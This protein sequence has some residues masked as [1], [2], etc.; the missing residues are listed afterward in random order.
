MVTSSPPAMGLGLEPAHPKVMKRPSRKGKFGIFT[1][2]VIVDIFFYGIL[3][4]T[5]CLAGF[6]IS[7]YVIGDGNL[8]IN[9]NSSGVNSIN[10]TT[11]YRSRTVSFISMS[12]LLLIHGWNCKDSQKSLFTM[13]LWENKFLFFSVII[14]LCLTF[15]TPYIPGI[16]DSVFKQGPIDVE[17][18]V[19][20][21]IIVLFVFGSEIY[22]LFK[23]KFWKALRIVSSNVEEVMVDEDHSDT[24]TN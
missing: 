21:C 6:M 24:D 19:I 14:G 23:R 20:G 12:S 15:P 7:L 9:C 17:W 18:A 16:H 10:C 3:M 4:G 2:E 8:G 1:T 5:L 22:K 11:V 13:N